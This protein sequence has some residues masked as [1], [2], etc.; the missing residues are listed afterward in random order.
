[1]KFVRKY[2]KNK[3]EMRYFCMLAITNTAVMRNF[4]IIYEVFNVISVSTTDI[5]LRLCT[6]G[7][8]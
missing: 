4:N 8:K 5:T 1:V 7:N 3:F 2:V 6:V